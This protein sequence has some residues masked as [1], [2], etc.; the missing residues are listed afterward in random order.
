M[1]EHSFDLPEYLV[2]EDML[3]FVKS[4]FDDGKLVFTF[5]EKP[6]GVK[7]QINFENDEKMEEQ[8]EEQTIEEN[9]SKV[10]RKMVDEIEKASEEIVPCESKTKE[11]ENDT[12]EFE[13]VKVVDADGNTDIDV[14]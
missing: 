6:V 3:K 14:E 1:G 12:V 2:K 9:N 4:E 7:M 13:I 5:P 8:S 11:Q 10:V